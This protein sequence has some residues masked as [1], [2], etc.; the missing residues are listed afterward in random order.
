MLIVDNGNRRIWL[1]FLHLT[2]MVFH[3]DLC[4]YDSRLILIVVVLVAFLD[5]CCELSI[6]F[7]NGHD[8]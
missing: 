8:L 4:T 3:G 2:A 7:L 6:S 5:A 1:G